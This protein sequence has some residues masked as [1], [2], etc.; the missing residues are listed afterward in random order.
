MNSLK[1]IE[2]IWNRLKWFLEQI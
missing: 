2:V 1:K